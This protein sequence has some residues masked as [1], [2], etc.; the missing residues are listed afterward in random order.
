MMNQ[1]LT[2]LEKKILDEVVRPALTQEK[3][4]ILGSRSTTSE[5]LDFSKLLLGVRAFYWNNGGHEWDRVL[6]DL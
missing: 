2:P 1:L 3:P 6:R 5:T 4:D